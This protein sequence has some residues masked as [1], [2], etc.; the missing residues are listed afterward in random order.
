MGKGLSINHFH[1]TPVYFLW[2]CTEGH[3]MLS[4]YASFNLVGQCNVVY[5]KGSIYSVT[6]RPKDYISFRKLRIGKGNIFLRKGNSIFLFVV[7]VIW[8]NILLY[9]VK[10][11]N[12]YCSLY[13]SKLLSFDI[14]MRYMINSYFQQVEF[15]EW[16]Q[17]QTLGTV[18]STD[19]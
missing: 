4:R 10:Q 13:V 19:K 17:L 16:S 14:K 12:K 1:S 5:T 3:K 15:I 11:R 6:F 9:Q 2:W 8:C 18:L 7:A